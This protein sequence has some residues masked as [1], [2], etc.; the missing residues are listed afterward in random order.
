ADASVET[1]LYYDRL[2]RNESLRSKSTTE[3]IDFTLEHRFAPSER[4]DLMWGVGYRFHESDV[5]KTAIAVNTNHYDL[6]LFSAFVQDEVELVPDALAVTAGVKLEH[7]DFTGAEVQ[8]SVRAMWR[9]SDAQTVWAAVGRSV[10][11]PSALEGKDLFHMEIGPP[12]PGPDGGLYIP[13][14]LGNAH[15]DSEVLWSYE[16]GWRMQV[17]PRVS[18][19]LATFYNRY[20]ELMT[21]SAMPRFVPGAPFGVAEI[22]FVNGGATETFGGEVAVNVAPTKAWRISASYSALEVRADGA[23][24]GEQYDPQRQAVLRSSHELGR[25]V[26]V[27]FQLRYVGGFAAPAFPIATAI[28]SYVGADVRIAYRPNDVLEISVVGRDLLDGQHP[29]QGPAI[30]SITSEVPRRVYGKVTWRF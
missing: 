1:Q 22:S 4:Q 24:A 12:S 19:D 29:E 27:D 21:F 5:W 17:S 10:R 23:I 7:N 20:D 15:P 25:R 13:T 8:P 2:T 18:V 14:V 11:T 6:K 26:S 16:L 30:Y 3:T 9:A 28:P